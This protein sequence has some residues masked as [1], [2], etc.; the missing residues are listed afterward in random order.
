MAPRSDELPTALLKDVSRSFYLTLRALPSAI[1]PQISVAYL[2]ARAS[3]TIADTEAFPKAQRLITLHTFREKMVQPS[4]PPLELAQMVA[5]QSAPAEQTLLR[6]LEEVFSMVTS[7]SQADQ[8]R[9]GQVLDIILSGQILDVER[10]VGADAN[11]IAALDTSAQL[12]DYTY[13]VAGCVGE[14]WT[15]MC[16]AHLFPDAP[17]DEAF[18]MSTG[19]RFGKGL[20]LTNILRDLPNDL[21]LGRCYLPLTKLRESGL[22]PSDLLDPAAEP[23]FRNLFREHLIIAEEHLRAGWAYTNHLP[24]RNVRVRLACA[25]PV[26]IGMQTLAKLSSANVLDPAQKVKGSRNMV[27][28]V[29]LR[30]VL[31]YPCQSRWQKLL[32]PPP[33]AVL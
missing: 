25:W 16:R 28:A 30:T 33:T 15:K 26:L 21:R 12:D 20:Q 5:S 8:A 11:H 31:W 10:F 29:L 6:R 18:L 14:F 4:R 13:R 24:F 32:P 27:R 22:D 17:I 3:D 2:L 9:I 1:R 19:V 23:R 7:F